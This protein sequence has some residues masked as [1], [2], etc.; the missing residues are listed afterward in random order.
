MDLVAGTESQIELAVVFSRL[1][2][3]DKEQG[4]QMSCS[5]I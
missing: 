5:V 2:V 1:D 4:F 3:K